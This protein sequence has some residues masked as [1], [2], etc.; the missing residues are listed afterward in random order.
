MFVIKYKK[1]FVGLSI[2]FV[3][4]SIAFLAVFKLNFGIDFTGGSATTL[5]YTARPSIETLTHALTNAGFGDARIQPEN[6]N[7][8]S[9]KTRALSDTERA[10]LVAAAQVSGTIAT[11]TGFTSIGPSIG[12]E[13]K[14][15][16]ITAL[17]LVLLA[18]ICFVAYAFRKVSEPVSSWKYGLVVIIALVHDVIIPSGVFALLGHFLGAEVD[19]LFIVALLTTLGLSVSDTIVVFDRI[20][21]HLKSAPKNKSFA[22]LVGESLS[23]TFV[24]SINTSLVVLVMVLSLAV[25]GPASTK[26]FAITLAVGMFF[27]T[28]SSIFLASPLLVIVERS[29]K[30]KGK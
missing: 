23:E 26:L 17:I 27:G 4:I 25:F 16:A 18:I 22:E 6:E 1:I 11:Q 28:Y 24:R 7:D 2:A 10:S 3:A 14:H 20:R 9:I 12:V 8:V 15:K 21:E 30:K 5:H 29:Q 13:L 19:T